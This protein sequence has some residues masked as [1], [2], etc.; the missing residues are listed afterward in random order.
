M[1]KK[2]VIATLGLMLSLAAV[3]YGAEVKGQVVDGDGR[4]QAE[5]KVEFFGDDHYSAWTDDTGSFSIEGVKPGEYKVKVTG[6]KR[7]S[8]DVVVDAEGMHPR[9]LVVDW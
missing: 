3:V 6:P 5:V 7:Q 9:R 4:A 2:L 1:R 8:F